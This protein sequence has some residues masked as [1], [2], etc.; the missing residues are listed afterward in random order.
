M[1]ER[2]LIHVLNDIFK[3]DFERSLKDVFELTLV[4][5]FEQTLRGDTE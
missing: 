2:T 3:N 1:F 4:H 5:V